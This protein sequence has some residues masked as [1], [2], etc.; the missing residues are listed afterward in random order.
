[1]PAPTAP[2][3]PSC[4]PRQIKLLAPGETA[5]LEVAGTVADVVYLGDHIKCSVGLADG[6]YSC[7]SPRCSGHAKTRARRTCKTRL[8]AEISSASSARDQREPYGE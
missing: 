6:V 1:M 8:V 3:V 2:S 4:V 5:E 7:C